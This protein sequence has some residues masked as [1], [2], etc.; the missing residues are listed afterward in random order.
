MSSLLGEGR[1]ITKKSQVWSWYPF[2]YNPDTH[3]LSWSYQKCSDIY[4]KLYKERSRELYIEMQTTILKNLYASLNAS[5]ILTYTTTSDKPFLDSFVCTLHTKESTLHPEPTYSVRS[6]TPRLPT[7]C[8]LYTKG[9]IQSRSD[10]CIATND[11][12]YI[13]YIHTNELGPPCYSVCWNWKQRNQFYK[14]IEIVELI[15]KNQEAGSWNVLKGFDRS[16]CILEQY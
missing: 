10:I 5:T 16:L 1:P 13:R 8:P 3:E 15:C 12:V 7:V 6:F 14:E 2:N 11:S 4:H 9:I